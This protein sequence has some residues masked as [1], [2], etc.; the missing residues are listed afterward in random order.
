MHITHITFYAFIQKISPWRG[1]STNDQMYKQA[2]SF[3]LIKWH[4]QHHYYAL[5]YKKDREN[6]DYNQLSSNFINCC[7]PK[8]GDSLCAWGSIKVI[9]I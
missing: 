3:S 6:H 8:Y 5:E 7:M 2:S 4:C 1:N 9:A